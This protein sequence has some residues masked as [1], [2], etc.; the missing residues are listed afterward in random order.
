MN[1]LVDEI[2]FL[3]SGRGMPY[4]KVALMVASVITVFFTVFLGYNYARDVNVVVVDLDHS[5]YSQEM[6]EAINSSRHM[7]V[8][9]VI[10]TPSDPQKFF[11]EDKAYA[12]ICLPKDLERDVYSGQSVNIGLYCD[13]TNVALTADIQTAMNELAG[14]IN[15]EAAEA[16]GQS[17]GISV[18]TR[19]LFN[20]S[21]STSNAETEGFLFF[22]SS[23]FFTFATI[24]MVPRLKLEHKW[25]DL[26]ERGSPFDLMVRILPYMGCLFTALLLGMAILRVWGDMV[27]S[28]NMLLFLGL[29][30]FYIWGVGMMSIL[31]G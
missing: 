25:E 10:Y 20:P 12:V 27:I 30:F 4:E 15:A 18:S 24:G 5:R 9:S 17:G 3:F 1:S 7:K 26:M 31:F 21:G 8:S 6:V 14:T 13:Y 28:G 16:K 2:H 29:Q 11:Y 23:M 19:L 22:F